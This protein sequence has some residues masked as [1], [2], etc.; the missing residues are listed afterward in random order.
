[1]LSKRERWVGIY[2]TILR[3]KGHPDQALNWDISSLS[4]IRKAVLAARAE[5]KVIQKALADDAVIFCLDD[6][7]IDQKQK[8]A[9]FLFSAIDVNASDP[10]FRN[11]KTFTTR[12]IKKGANEGSAVA[13][14]LVV[15]FDVE[16]NSNRYPTALEQIEGVSRSRILPMLEELLFTYCG[17][18]TVDNDG[19][20]ERA[21]PRLEMQAKPSET[22]AQSLRSG[23]LLGVSLL[24]VTRSRKLDKGQL[25]HEAEK[26][27][28]FKVKR[29]SGDVAKS[30]I[31]EIR[32]K[33]EYRDLNTMR[34]R[35][36][37]AD[38]KH[39]TLSADTAQMDAFE[40]SF[41]RVERIT[42]TETDLPAAHEKINTEVASSML[43]LLSDKK[44]P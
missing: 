26:A 41:T 42:V 34:V 33:P 19:A 27:V 31:S 38:G 21:D 43:D 10:S 39:L 35:Y 17:Q 4:K 12:H 14:H 5:Q 15:A 24:R 7:E 18:V 23:E 25:Y 16:Q 30:I 44:K 29:T 1:M 37:R 3:G 6:L 20:P 40:K 32:G 2:E 13:A 28:R 11:T 22:L 36:R 8:V 9:T